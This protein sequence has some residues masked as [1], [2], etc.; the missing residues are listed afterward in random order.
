MLY[1]FFLTFRKEKQ[2][3]KPCKKRKAIVRPFLKVQQKL[4]SNNSRSTGS[5]TPSYE[6]QT[7]SPDT[8]NAVSV[9]LRVKVG[10]LINNSVY[11]NV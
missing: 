9:L 7:T 6:P 11:V 8:I 4:N 1:I 3:A 2:S 10:I 5:S